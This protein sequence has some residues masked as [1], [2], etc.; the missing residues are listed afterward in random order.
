VRWR[1]GKGWKMA[2]KSVSGHHYSWGR[3]SS[4]DRPSRTNAGGGTRTRTGI[5]LRWFE[6]DCGRAPSTWS[7]MEVH[8]GS[9]SSQTL[10][11]S[12]RLLSTWRYM[13]G[14][15]V[16]HGFS[17]SDVGKNVGSDDDA[18]RLVSDGFHDPTQTAAV[19]CS[20]TAPTRRRHGE[21]RRLAELWRSTGSSVVTS[22]QRWAGAT[23]E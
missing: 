5:A 23:Q 1:L 10:C 3:S 14:N 19:A 17:A 2:T 6:S 21:H 15:G 12:H 13:A 16:D 8:S 22:S 4:T 7:Y 9:S 18:D 20:A 11:R